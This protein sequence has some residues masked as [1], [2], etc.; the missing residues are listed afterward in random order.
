MLT[1]IDRHLIWSY[2]K[3]YAVCLVSMMGLFVV[4]DLFTNL[5]KFTQN[6]KGF[7]PVMQHIGLVYANKLPQIFNHL[8]E[9]IGLLAGMFTVAWMQ[10][11]N[12][13]LPLL[14]AGVSTRRVVRPVL[15]SA[16]LVMGFCVLNQE[17]VLPRV[18]NYIVEN[19]GDP[20]GKSE[21]AV[22]GAF[23]ANGVL[24]MGQRAI[25]GELLVREFFVTLPPKLGRDALVK[26]EAKEAR[27]VPPGEGP[28][29]GGWMLTGT[30]T[31]PPD[32][33]VSIAPEI[34][35]IISPGRFF[36]KTD[37]DFEKVT[38]QKNWWLCLST[39]D[40]VRDLGKADAQGSRLASLAVLF[41]SRLT[42]PFLAMIL[43][44]LGLSVILR[45]QN[46][47]FFISAGLCLGLCA[48]FF[49]ACFFCKYLG[50]YD[51]LSPALA[52][53]LPVIVFGPLSLVMF[54]AV[55]T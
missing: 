17:F 35:D 27:Y 3:A 23:D 18:D 21:L 12:E 24:F 22:N 19:A 52:A 48:L 25:R 38:R 2:L 11:N 15:I 14:S 39:W 45:D 47:N 8:C 42:R 34:L 6:S 46:R 7:G 26:L 49:F 9:A 50:E 55:H 36:L 54:D 31:T 5:D 1:L 44:I 4:V 28:R 16:C 53:W 29:T 51:H 33:D 40:L 43:V 10:R 13:L 37:V 41:H 20:E 32:I 30:T